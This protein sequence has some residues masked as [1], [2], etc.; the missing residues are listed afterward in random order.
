MPPGSPIVSHRKNQARGA[1]HGHETVGHA[2]QEI[3]A[4]LRIMA[5]RPAAAAG[6]L[7][8][9]KLPLSPYTPLQNATAM[10]QG[11]RCRQRHGG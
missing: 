2:Y 11:G 4:S 8:V 9:C 1:E 7:S 10:A 3:K 5:V 6:G